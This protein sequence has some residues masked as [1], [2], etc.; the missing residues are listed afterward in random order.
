VAPSERVSNLART[1]P[2]TV[3]PSDRV[4][5]AAR[6]LSEHKVSAVAVVGGPHL[7]LLTTT[8]ILEHALRA[9]H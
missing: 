8:D 2:V 6:L 3:A 5:T 7:G 9:L 4:S 1:S